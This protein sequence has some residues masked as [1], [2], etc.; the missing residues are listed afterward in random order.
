MTALTFIAYCSTR[1]LMHQRG[2]KGS[3]PKT[4]V[5][6]TDAFLPHHDTAAP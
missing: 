5:L 2:P 1:M 4:H 3:I 6:L